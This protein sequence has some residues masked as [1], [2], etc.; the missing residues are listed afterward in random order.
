M[1][2]NITSK[3]RKI[4]LDFHTPAWVENIGEDFSADE[5][6]NTLQ[7]AGVDNIC[8]FGKCCHG[9][10]YYD[11]ITGTRH[12]HL[13]FDLLKEMVDAL[14]KA[15][16]GVSVY[17]TVVWD[18]L[19]V[20]E[21]PDWAQRDAL[22]NPRMG[23][24]DRWRTVCVNSPYTEEVVI[25]QIKEIVEGYDPDELWFDMLW[26]V[27]EECFCNYCREKM[28]E[29]GKDPANRN[30]RIAFSDWTDQ[31]FMK[32]VSGFAKSLKPEIV[33]TYNNC[34]R[35]GAR[36]KIPYMDVFEIESLPHAWGY[37]Y[38][39]LYS[40]YI[41][42]LRIPVKG[43]TCRF[44]KFWGDFG[45]L[46]P[47]PQ[48]QFEAASMISQGAG[49]IIGDQLYPRAQLEPAAYDNVG[50]VFEFI[51]QREPYSIG[52]EPVTQIALLGDNEPGS[53]SQG[54]PSPQLLGSLK[55]LMELHHQFDVIDE[56]AEFSGYDVI[57]VADAVTPSPELKQ[58]LEDYV[59]NGGKLLF[60][61][62]SLTNTDRSWFQKQFQM[63]HHGSSGYSMDYIMPIDERLKNNL[64]SMEMIVY[65]RF[66][67]VHPIGNVTILA[68]AIHPLEERTPVRYMSHLQASPG[69]RS[70]Y[71]AILS[72]DDSV[73]YFASPIFKSYFESGNPLLRHMVAGALQILLPDPVVESN[74]PTSSEITLLQKDNKLALHLTNYSPSRRG[75]HPE[76]VDEIRPLH[77]IRLTVRWTK[78][79][80][81]VT[82]FPEN[83]Q[84]EF[85]YEDNTISIVVPRIDIHTGV[86]IEF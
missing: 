20:D 16:I 3:F 69:N 34:V 11:T 35:I 55:M 1:L 82:L 65:D 46:K 26:V 29:Q 57:V 33:V 40:R 22:G 66:E 15:S 8:V 38:F 14:R 72:I 31:Q 9:L 44:H 21:H 60:T 76:V 78:K 24:G 67:K 63:E 32:K 64:P 7:K 79:P 30:D 28:I 5:F 2:E 83:E 42:T 81:K 85:I 70:D 86:C 10:S 77:D 39:P 25:P 84:V 19:V 50:E 48:L 68:E 58:K 18:D 4:H 27:D 13:Q 47:V 62:K 56:E 52:W 61:G 53:T 51:K 59:K 12:P 37:W 43:M 75:N 17:Y 80:K 41:R 74:A 73:L 36:K 6:V 54:Q 71:P 45:S 23:F 49:C